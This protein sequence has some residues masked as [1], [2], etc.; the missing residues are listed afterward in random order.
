MISLTDDNLMAVGVDHARAVHPNPVNAQGRRKQPGAPTRQIVH[1]RLTSAPNRGRVKEQQIC[2]RTR[3]DQTPIG[4]AE[5]RSRL[6]GEFSDRG[7]E[8]QHLT[9]AHPVPQQMKTEASVIEKREV[10]ASI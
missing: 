8:A 4:Q 10:R 5:Q 9:I 3:P 1:A 7:G 2:P 6:S